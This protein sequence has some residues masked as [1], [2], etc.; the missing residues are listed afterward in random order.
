[1]VIETAILN[2]LKG[3]ADWRVEHVVPDNN[4]VASLI[5]ASVSKEQRYQSY[6]ASGGPS[7]L[8]AMLSHEAAVPQH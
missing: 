7:W 1:M 3:F 4:K 8:R 5:A 2:S 6:V